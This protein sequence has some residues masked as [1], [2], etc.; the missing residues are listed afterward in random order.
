M[1]R[2]ASTAPA[3]DA[4]IPTNTLVVNS[5]AYTIKAGFSN[6][7]D[8]DPD[9]TSLDNCQV[10]PNCIARSRL[11]RDYIGSALSK[12]TDYGELAIKRP[13][14]KGYIVNWETEKAIWDHEFLD[15]KSPLH[16]DPASTN[17]ILTEPPNSPLALQTNTDQIIFEE[18]QFAS[19]YRCLGSTL[20]AWNDNA[21]L[22]SDAV[23]LTS[24]PTEI[25]LQIDSGHSHTNIVPVFR[26]RALQS[27]IRR[28]DMGGKHLSNYL[29]ELLSLRHFSLI[30]EP[31]IVSQIKEDACF[32]SLDFDRDLERTWKGGLGDRR[33]I[34]KEIVKDYVL[35]DYE[36]LHRGYLREHDASHAAKMAR[37]GVANANE[38][39]EKEREEAF[40]LANE[41]FVVPELLFNPRDVGL[42][43][44]G[45]AD[46]VMESLEAL[47]R[48]MWQGFL[49][50]IVLVGGCTLLPG[51]VERVESGIRILAPAEMEVRVRRPEDPIKYTWQGGA[52]LAAQAEHLKNAV[53]TREQYLEHGERWT[54]EQ[55]AKKRI[56]QDWTRG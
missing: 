55:F 52:R 49:G 35:P 47:P 56:V 10:V 12:C 11:R 24:L 30:D 48:P 37:L 5:G 29:A 32:V 51:F 42:Q 34:D 2:Q 23:P 31:Y 4:P 6:S 41:R 3:T 19:L 22:F 9:T 50:N 16:C 7:D 33:P 27:A 44:S 39:G 38:D 21:A 8:N 54:R 46:T 40:P 53:V 1:A 13:V 14:E 18:Y 28:I 43:Q 15:A 17:L 36:K 45:I 20:A 25:M 26:G